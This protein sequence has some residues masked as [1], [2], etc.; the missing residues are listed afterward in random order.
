MCIRDRAGSWE[1]DII[2]PG[3]KCNMT[4]IMASI[5]LVQLDRYP[6][7]LERRLEL[8]EQYNEGFKGSKV[9][10]LVHNTKDHKSSNHLYI[11]HVEG[12][13]FE[14]RGKI[15]TEMAERGISCN[16]HYKP[17][18]YTHLDVYKRQT[19]GCD[20]EVTEFL[21]ELSLE[22]QI[23]EFKKLLED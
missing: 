23:Q 20:E 22:K 17:V 13:T 14:Q 15:I 4:D 19:Q 7:L 9:K 5:G 11:T 12:A 8:V 2:I 16:V 1:Y 21:K 18:S 6:K 10:P 3:Y